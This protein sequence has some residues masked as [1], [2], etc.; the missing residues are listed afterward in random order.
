M[1][2]GTLNELINTRSVIKHIRKHNKN[3]KQGAGIGND[4]SCTDDIV[5]AEAVGDTPYIAWVKAM[6]N[7]AVSGTEISGVRI[8]LLLPEITEESEIKQY[9]KEFN[10]LADD[11][12]VQIL[13]GHSQVSRAYNYVNF[14]V[15]VYGRNIGNNE[16]DVRYEH[17]TKAIDK[18]CRILMVGYAGLMGTDILARTKFDELRTRFSESYIKDAFVC[19]KS[20]CI[21]DSVKKL[22][23]LNTEKILYM[24]DVSHGGI[25]GALWQLGSK[26]KKGIKVNNADIP[27]KQETIEICEFFNLN[28]YMLEGTGAFLAVIKPDTHSI[29]EDRE[30]VLIN[31]FSEYGIEAAFIGNV[32]D[33]NDKAVILGNE[34]NPELRYLSPVKG[35]EI[36]KVV[37]RF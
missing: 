31:A 22:L 6:N 10:L 33:S 24:H 21:S 14:V 4:Y 25:Y 9:M 5:A 26:I 28:P 15:T 17:N 37:T 34:D 16:K 12:G 1:E 35:D 29:G 19:R 30:Q 13:G 7:M 20:Y 32:T 3:M 27:I 18:N 8:I 36:Y 2:L 11:S 23:E